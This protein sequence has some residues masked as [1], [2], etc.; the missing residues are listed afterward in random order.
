MDLAFSIVAAS[1]FMLLLI[2]SVIMLF[3]IYLKRKNKLLLER[4]RIS[5][6]FEQ[7]LLHSKVAIQEETFT[8]V[9]REIHDNIGQVLSLVR[10]NI[11]TMTA[12]PSEDKIQLMDEMMG[13]A[14]ADLR[15]L[16]H[17]LDTGMI[18]N[19]GWI[20]AAERLF[21]DLGRSGTKV[22]FTAE[23]NLPT[24]GDEKPII[25]FRMIQEIINNT[26]KHAGAKEIK[27]DA[28]KKDG[29]IIIT[30]SDNGKGFDP[31]HIVAGA[32]LQNLENRAKMI[33]ANLQIH[34]QPG[35]GTEVIISV[36]ALPPP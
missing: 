12:T 20:K 27:F 34:T 24:L 8:K 11:N 18:R 35:S 30:I 4:E 14:I 16:S 23:E 17:S 5:I 29:Q 10:L 7:T 22:N 26:I 13:K 33:D 1:M 36:N 6:Q 32:G 31:A 25:L 21:R 9:S 28:A 15:G 19:T 3:H 2:A